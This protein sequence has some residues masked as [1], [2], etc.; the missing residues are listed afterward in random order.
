MCPILAEN[1]G[2]M[3]QTL[4]LEWGFWPSL[5]FSADSHTYNFCDNNIGDNAVL[6]K[7]QG[8]GDCRTDKNVNVSSYILCCILVYFIE[9][10]ETNDT[11]NFF[12][13]LIDPFLNGT[14]YFSSVTSRSMTVRWSNASSALGV[15]YP[16]SY[17]SSGAPDLIA[18]V[19][20]F[21]LT[22]LTSGTFY[23]FSIFARINTYQAAKSSPSLQCSMPTGNVVSVI[24]RMYRTLFTYCIV[25]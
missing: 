4:S 9:S 18:S 24:V 25:H 8:I 14:C 16:M 11:I 3:R 21:S 23:S 13:Y 15:D 1:T 2:L 19:P 7:K 5:N 22:N 12:L 10:I 6:K 17:R 20:V